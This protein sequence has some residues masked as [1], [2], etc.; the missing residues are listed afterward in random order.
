M[1]VGYVFD[2]EELPKLVAVVPGRERIFFVNPDLA[3][4]RGFLAGIL[5]YQDGRSPY[6]YHE[7]CE[8]FYLVFKGHG[9]LV[10]EQGTQKLHPGHLV[11]IPDRERHQ[12]VA[13]GPDRLEFM[14]FQAPN[15]FKTT[16]LEGQEDDLRW[17]REDGSVWQQT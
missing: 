16:I 1:R 2:Q 8:H 14:E 10:T 5:R 12:M 15:R 17:F 7:G 13:D 3:N 4:H 11:F 6:H 9:T